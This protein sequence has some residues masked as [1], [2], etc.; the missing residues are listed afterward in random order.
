MTFW[1]SEKTNRVNR[2]KGSMI[3]G[4]SFMSKEITNCRRP[5]DNDARPVSWR[6]AFSVI[7]KI[8]KQLAPDRLSSILL[9]STCV[10]KPHH[11]IACLIFLKN[12]INRNRCIRYTSIAHVLPNALGPDL[13]HFSF[14]AMRMPTDTPFEIFLQSHG[15]PA[16]IK[17]T[18]LD[19]VFPN[20]GIREDCF[21]LC[22]FWFVPAGHDF[23]WKS[24][25]L[26]LSAI[27]LQWTRTVKGLALE[28]LAQH[29][30]SRCIW[31]ACS[32]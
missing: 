19:A 2:Y 20:S 6:V 18:Q 21:N 1:R 14:I 5:L 24:D 4:K 11:M 17:S 32:C 23:V 13:L 22:W 29:V 15:R 3:F 12:S 31:Y 28:H 7:G 10:G 25:N 30:E 27:A 8:P 26:N 9:L 16:K